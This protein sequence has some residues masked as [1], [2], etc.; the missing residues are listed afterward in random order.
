MSIKEILSKHGVITADGWSEDTKNLHEDLTKHVIDCSIE[1][2]EHVP[3][4][5]KATAQFI[6]ERVAFLK[7]IR[8]LKR[9][10]KES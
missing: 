3:I 10:P 2:L 6:D 7:Y 5:D 9:L 4:V 1:E 8:D